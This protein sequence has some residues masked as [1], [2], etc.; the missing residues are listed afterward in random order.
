[1]FQVRLSV[2]KGLRALVESCPRSHVAM[3]KVLPKIS[4]CLHDINE[5]VRSAV[6]DLLTEVKKIRTI[7]YF[8][9]CPM[10]DIL[11]RMEVDKSPNVV[12]KIASLIL[13]S[14]FPVGDNDAQFERCVKF[15]DMNGNASRK[16]YRYLAKKASVH[17]TVL[18]MLTVLVKIK[19]NVFALNKDFVDEETDED[20]EN[21]GGD[22]CSVSSGSS[23]KT[24]KSSS[25]TTT[26]TTP[27]SS[28]SA[29]QNKLNDDNIVSGLLDTV[30][31]MW[32]M[33]SKELSLAENTQYRRLMEKKSGKILTVLF[34][35]YKNSDIVKTV[36]Y[37]C[38]MLPHNH[39]STIAGFCLSKIKK[40][41]ETWSYVDCLCNWGRGD[42]LSELIIGWIKND[43]LIRVESNRKKVRAV[44]F[45]ES[46]DSR[47]QTAVIEK[48]TRALKMVKYITEHPVN[49]AMMLKKNRANLEEI[50]LVLEKFLP[51]LNEDDGDSGRI[52][53]AFEV[54]LTLTVLLHTKDNS[55]E[56]LTRVEDILTH[57]YDAPAPILEKALTVCINMITIG[58]CDVNFNCHVVELAEKSR[59]GRLC[60][61]LCHEIASWVVVRVNHGNKDDYGMLYEKGIPDIMAKAVKE[62]KRD[63]EDFKDV[64][65]KIHS[66]LD[67]Y[68]EHFYKFNEETLFGFVQILLEAFLDSSEQFAGQI[69]PV[70]T[71]K[72]QMTALLLEELLHWVQNRNGDR[73]NIRES[74]A[75]LTLLKRIK[76]QSSSSSRSYK[77]NVEEIIEVI[78]PQ[79]RE[80][81]EFHG[82][83]E[84]RKKFEDLKNSLLA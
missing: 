10:E 48:S 38:S 44:R 37:L 57:V 4:D 45:E 18:F 75:I 53:E 65:G 51:V 15:V 67:M 60:I 58:V 3:H 56:T 68:K 73:R 8:S 49:R 24:V 7:A 62:I 2:I 16:F 33:K 6:V 80:D 20:K 31:I 52:I 9:V 50:R 71:C 78:Q 55:E 36:A 39:V 35:H 14:F 54:L 79:M 23:K 19:K 69:S 34:K 22:R 25:S 32:V 29:D 42:D 43:P 41:D 84:E 59:N 77:S 28:S 76:C 64:K 40:S 63:E 17:D 47:D 21:E 11:A 74:V 83:L 70:F 82:E 46:V 81:D 12:R 27:S 26:T 1:M 61:L 5:A 13:N 30:A 66:L 72:P